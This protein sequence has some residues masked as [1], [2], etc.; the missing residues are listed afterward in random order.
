MGMRHKVGMG[1]RKPK[2]HMVYI[3]CK[4]T[5]KY[6]E[7]SKYC[8]SRRGKQRKPGNWVITPTPTPSKPVPGVV[9]PRKAEY[10][11]CKT[12]YF[13]FL[14]SSGLKITFGLLDQN[15]RVIK[16]LRVPMQSPGPEK[17]LG[18]G[19]G[20]PT[21][22][23]ITPGSKRPPGLEEPPGSQATFGS[24]ATSG[25][26]SDLRVQSNLRVKTTSG[27]RATSGFKMTSGSRR[28]LRIPKRP[29]GLEEPTVSQM[30]S[31][32]LRVPKR[33]LG[34]YSTF[35]VQVK[36]QDLKE[37]LRVP[38]RPL[39]PDTISGSK[40]DT[41]DFHMASG[42]KSDLRVHKTPPGYKQPPGKKRRSMDPS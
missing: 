24:R 41:P 31:G 37:N 30:T 28:N 11:P 8:F 14:R 20:K 25:F 10:G 2:E 5:V 40:G 23:Y 12:K 27:S 22:S 4:S 7:Q 13:G 36:S 42:S 34:P 9:L 33:P 16:N 15:P 29:P 6:M 35:G 3:H 38:T 32:N 21:G 19:K 17:I 26:P 18:P 39:G 1:L